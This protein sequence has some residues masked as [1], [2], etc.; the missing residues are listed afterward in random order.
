MWPG[1]QEPLWNHRPRAEAHLR[2]HDHPTRAYVVCR[3]PNCR[4]R[5]ALV[6]QH[7]PPDQRIERVAGELD[8]AKV[9][10]HELDVFD[11]R[12]GRPL[13]CPRQRLLVALDPDYQ[14]VG[15]D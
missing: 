9:T 2:K 6:H 3:G 15:A 4:G 10:E 8:V 7:E 1:H 5:V 12:L 14:T 11:V 13:T